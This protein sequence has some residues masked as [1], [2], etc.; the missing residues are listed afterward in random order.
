MPGMRWEEISLLS[1]KHSCRVSNNFP[2]VNSMECRSQSV[3]SLTHLFLRPYRTQSNRCAQ[4]AAVN[5]PCR[6]NMS[7]IIPDV[8][9]TS[10][11]PLNFA[12]R[13]TIRQELNDMRIRYP[14]HL[15]NVHSY[16]DLMAIICPTGRHYANLPPN[17]QEALAWVRNVLAILR[18]TPIGNTGR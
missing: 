3:T 1:R 7:K 18:Y 2:L 17:S 10:D 16:Q 6:L 5:A 13:H 12:Q 4:C 9:L 15:A 14:I 8:P 11:D